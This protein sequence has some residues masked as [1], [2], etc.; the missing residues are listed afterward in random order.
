MLY[1]HLVSSPLLPWYHFLSSLSCVP[2]SSVQKV[3][4]NGHRIPFGLIKDAKQKDVMMSCSP[5]GGRSSVF[6][7]KWWVT[8][9][10]T[11]LPGESC[12]ARLWLANNQGVSL[13]AQCCIPRICVNQPTF[14]GLDDLSKQLL[15]WQCRNCTSTNDASHHLLTQQRWLIRKSDIKI[16]SEPKWFIFSSFASRVY[17]EADYFCRNTMNRT[18]WA[19][20]ATVWKL[21][22]DNPCSPPCP[23]PPRG[24]DQITCLGAGW[25][26]ACWVELGVGLCMEQGLLSTD[27]SKHLVQ[28]YS[29]SGIRST[30]HGD[31]SRPGARWMKCH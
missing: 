13:R 30:C 5:W 11:I 27:L 17:A 18:H 15:F 14:T 26:V 29:D 22:R 31:K 1:C 8:K 21:I 24:M 3:L 20:S 2:G 28:P 9:N 4:Y 23:P 6:Y 10:S 12:P 25:G 7:W 19:T 16:A